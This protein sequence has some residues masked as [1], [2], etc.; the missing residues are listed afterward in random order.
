M[1]FPRPRLT[2]NSG[3]RVSSVPAVRERLSRGPTSP[4][5]CPSRRLRATGFHSPA[6]SPLRH[7]ERPSDRLLPDPHTWWHRHV[8]QPSA[9]A[10]DLLSTAPE[11]ATARA[12][13]GSKA[14]IYPMMP[15]TVQAPGASRSS[16]H[17]IRSLDGL[18]AVFY[19]GCGGKPHAGVDAYSVITTRTHHA[20]RRRHLLTN[21]QQARLPS[22]SQ[23]HVAGLG[24]STIHCRLGISPLRYFWWL[25]EFHTLMGAQGNSDSGLS[26]IPPLLRRS[27]PLP[28]MRWCA[29][30]LRT[31]RCPEIREAMLH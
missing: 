10:A 13:R 7:Q 12:A 9:S 22:S 25:D 27:P 5:G 20:R 2:P 17:S 24:P 15:G 19:R 30:H 28:A 6:L 29:W 31:L 14:S 18:R 3:L 11:L 8:R 16:F 21:I 26:S 23:P 1:P 4:F